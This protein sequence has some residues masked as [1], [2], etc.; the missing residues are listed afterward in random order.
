M[1]PAFHLLQFDI[2][3]ESWKLHSGQMGRRSCGWIVNSWNLIRFQKSWM[4]LDFSDLNLDFQFIVLRP[5]VGS[6]IATVDCQMEDSEYSD[7]G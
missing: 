3:L 7:G 1:A 5:I 6:S 4:H 2:F